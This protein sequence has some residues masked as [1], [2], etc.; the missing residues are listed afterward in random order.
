MCDDPAAFSRN[1]PT[2]QPPMRR[3][4]IASLLSLVALPAFAAADPTIIPFRSDSSGQLPER[5]KASGTVIRTISWTDSNGDN[6]AV[7][8]STTTTK[9]KKEVTLTTKS[10]FVDVFNGKNG[11]LKKVRNVREVVSNCDADVTNDLF[12][13][14][15]GVTDLDQNG[16]GELTFGYRSACRSDMSPAAMKVLVLEGS[17]KYILRGQTSL[18]SDKA[19]DDAFSADFKGAPGKFLEHAAKVW[20][21]FHI[22]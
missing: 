9:T 3:T 15:V 1:I 20:K 17:K 14:S 22:E 16:V 11:K 18:P 21:K 12:D 7:F 13:T 2:R 19:A 8:S 10:L 5:V 6:V 4:I